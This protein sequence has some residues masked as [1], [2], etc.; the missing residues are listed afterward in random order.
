MVAR[1]GTLGR[2]RLVGTNDPDVL[3]G[4]AL[5]LGRGQRGGD[6]EITGGLGNDILFGNAGNHAAPTTRGVLAGAVG[7]RDRIYGGDGRDIVAGDGYRLIDRAVG[8]NDVIY[9]DAGNDPLYGDALR[10][11]LDSRAAPT[12]SSAMPVTTPS[13]VTPTKA[14]PMRAVVPTRSTAETG[15]MSSPVTS[16]ATTARRSA[17]GTCWSAGPATTSSSS[18]RGATRSGTSYR[19]KTSSISCT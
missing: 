16:P 12:R 17:A 2:D 7:G 15:T 3:V 4:D 19:V 18:V 5:N 10:D 14:G 8:G 9:G 13:T 6:D 11:L 1:T